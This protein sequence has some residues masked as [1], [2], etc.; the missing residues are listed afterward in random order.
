MEREAQWEKRA[1]LLAQGN[2]RSRSRSVGSDGGGSDGRRRREEP[3]AA[4]D[5][6]LV[7]PGFLVDGRPGAGHVR[8]VSDE[9]SDVSAAALRAVMVTTIHWLLTWQH[10]R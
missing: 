6:A 10:N 1:T 3:S 8:R 5:G 7:D 2:M 4:S 9:Q